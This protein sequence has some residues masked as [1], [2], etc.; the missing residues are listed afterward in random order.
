MTKDIAWMIS[1]CNTC[2][3]FQVRQCNLPLEKQPTPDCPWQ[4]M[5][6]DLFDFN[7]GQYI[8]MADMYS[9]MC[10]VQKMPSAIVTSAAIISKMK[11]I[12][13]EHGVP[14]VLRRDNGP[15]YASAAFTEFVDEWGFQPTTSSPHYLAWNQFAEINDED[16]QDCFHKAKYSAK[17]PNLLYWHFVVHQ[18]TLTYQHWCD[19]CINRSWKLDC[20]HNHQIL[21][22]SIWGIK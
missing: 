13:A 5:A 16:H 12:F 19:C 20:P 10:F 6:S 17:D 11:E 21:I 8:A 15:Q 4:I 18:Y 22:M 2:Q 3:H 14:N 7:G 1:S 9:K